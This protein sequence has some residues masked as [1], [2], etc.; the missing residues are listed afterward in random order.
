MKTVFLVC[1]LFVYYCH[2][3]YLTQIQKDQI[4]RI[5]PDP[6]IDD[7][8]KEQLK[9]IIVSKYTWWA[10]GESKRFQK[11]Y[12]INPNYVRCSEMNQ[13]AI[14]GLIRSMKNYDGRVSVPFY[15]RFYVRDDLYRCFTERHGFGRYKHY[16][17]MIKKHKPVK[18]ERVEPY[19]YNHLYI[20]KTKFGYYENDDRRIKEEIVIELLNQISSFDKRV[21]LLRY[22][23]Y[24][25][26]KIRVV[27]DIAKLMC[28]SKETIRQSLSRTIK[29]I[30]SNSIINET[31]KA[32][33]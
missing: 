19:G 8:K 2:A 28:C 6:T 14:Y 29:Y 18:E 26:K 30:G 17:L 27:Q 33:L 21:F 3:Y 13:A 4:R 25:M 24:S 15:S 31:S 1:S 10:I 32:Y 20:E 12:N 22:D 16:D 11:Q 9:K 23:I 5:L 7:S